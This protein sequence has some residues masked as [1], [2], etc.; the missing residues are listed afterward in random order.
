MT[1]EAERE[2]RRAVNRDIV[3]YLQHNARR[4]PSTIYTYSFFGEEGKKI[5]R[6][7]IFYEN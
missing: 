7:V 6:K 3:D 2:K 1:E 4:V 5:N